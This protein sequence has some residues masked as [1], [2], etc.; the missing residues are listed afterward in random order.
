M[1]SKL[2]AP[3]QPSRLSRS[4]TSL[5][6][7]RGHDILDLLKERAE[8][9]PLA[10]GPGHRRKTAARLPKLPISAR[11]GGHSQKCFGHAVWEVSCVEPDPE[12]QAVLPKQGFAVQAAME[13]HR[14]GI[15]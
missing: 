14:T 4:A 15:A 10:D 13:E 3:L 2:P 1:S 6:Q 11:D 8:L 5:F 9:Q 12:N 7:Y